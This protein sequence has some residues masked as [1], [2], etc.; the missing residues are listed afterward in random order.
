MRIFVKI[1]DEF[2]DAVWVEMI[3]V[4]IDGD[5]AVMR[6]DSVDYIPAYQIINEYFHEEDGDYVPEAA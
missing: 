6:G 3:S 4:G 5:V 2:N 1:K